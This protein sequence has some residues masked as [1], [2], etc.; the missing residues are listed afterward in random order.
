[1][2]EKYGV[3]YPSQSDKIKE[4]I[5]TTNI[6]KYGVEYPAQNKEIIEKTKNT[7]IQKYGGIGFA[8]NEINTK[9]KESNFKKFNTEIPQQTEEIKEKVKQTNI[10]KYGTE[11]SLHNKD[12]AKKV[13]ETNLK[14]YG[15]SKVLASPEIQE[16][17]KNTIK[18]KYNTDNVSKLKI[19]Q[20][21]I[22]ETNLKRYGV[23]IPILNEK[24]KEKQKQTVLQNNLAKFKEQC[25]D[26]IAYNN[27]VISGICQI[28]KEKYE[29][30]R[31]MFYRRLL[32]HEIPCINC[33]PI[34]KPYS[35][36]EKE[37]V[38]F[39]SSV[40]NGKILE[41][42]K[43]ILNNLELDI[44]LPEKN[45]AIEYDG[46]FWHSELYRDKNYHLNK[47]ELC[48]AKGIQLI[49]IFEDEWLY[50][51]EIVKSR[52]KGLLGLNERLYARKCEV[53]EVSYKDSKL[54]LEINHIQGDCISKYRYGLYYNNELV[55]L[56]TFGKSRFS[57]EF[58]L[59]RFC[60]KLNTNVVGGASRLFKY[61][62]N[63]H[64]EISE[65][66]SFADR[67]W[68][69]GNMYEKLGFNLIQKTPPSY[70]YIIDNNRYNRFNF[71]KHKLITDENKANL[72]EHGIM[73]ANDIFRIYD[74]G[75]LKYK[76]HK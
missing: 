53:K 18:L 74:C 27:G 8:S 25:P 66:I 48:E 43:L 65:I 9:I 76:Y 38:E 41:N 12:I 22:K 73:L 4:K 70:F 40:Y 57:K 51:S 17:I 13:E 6:K 14:N 47:T 59:L 28:C 10:K 56:M 42:T 34:Y 29:I 72:T 63:N 33:N 50:K 37:I 61:F 55:S 32:H 71:Q 31:Q 36:S 75:N 44:Y 60:N 2:V 46:L 21:K 58:E 3:E 64:S 30:T 67:R 52:I 39:L 26:V 5:K 69:I 54:F 68:S 49:H 20:N 23:E 62:L 24:I 45:L 1:M 16:K 15:N 19:I 35:R 7:S 11:C